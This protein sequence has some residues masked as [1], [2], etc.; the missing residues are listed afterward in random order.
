MSTLADN[1]SLYVSGEL[2]E[3]AV[4]HTC[5]E[6]KRNDSQKY[7]T[8]IVAGLTWGEQKNLHQ[9]GKTPKMCWGTSLVVVITKLLTSKSNAAGE[10]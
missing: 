8:T 1:T 3:T 9:N 4:R 10:I 2:S 7:Q 6:N 5:A